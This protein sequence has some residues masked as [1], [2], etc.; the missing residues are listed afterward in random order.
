[1]P[2][3]QLILLPGLGGGPDLFLEQRQH[4]GRRLMTP[5]APPAFREETLAIYA[6]RW[7]RT[8]AEQELLRAPYIVGGISFGGQVAL[9]MARWAP[10]RPLAV[11]L[12]S[13]NRTS[14]SIPPDFRER[15]RWGRLAPGFAVKLA[16]RVLSGKFADREHL[17]PAHR[18]VLN[19]MAAE[20]DVDFLK[21][22]A[23]AAA[24]WDFSE[25]DALRL[26][27][28]VFQIHGAQDW[29]IPLDR[30]HPDRVLPD[31]K[32]LIPFTHANAVNTYLE[33]IL[34]RTE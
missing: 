16:L 19:K 29:V 7:S 1:M 8:L 34:R 9:E 18:T 13:A 12:I 14:A 28:P 3:P 2:E 33:V 6:A 11:V 22:G 25:E 4:F 30:S 23:R 32:H 27:V 17:S 31:G 26:A 20:A 5:A 10:V 15:Q 24:E 21:W